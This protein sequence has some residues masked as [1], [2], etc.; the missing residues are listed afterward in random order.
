MDSENFLDINIDRKLLILSICDTFRAI[1]TLSEAAPKEPSQP[2]PQPEAQITVFIFKPVFDGFVAAWAQKEYDFR[3]VREKL[4]KPIV[5]FQTAL[6]NETL[7]ERFLKKK[8]FF[9][10]ARRS[11]DLLL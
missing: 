10:E 11:H 8:T 4:H 5:T 9:Q 1:R 7:E 2:H 3:K 6:I